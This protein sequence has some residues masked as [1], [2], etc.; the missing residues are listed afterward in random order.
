MHESANPVDQA[1]RERR[2]IRAFLP[3]DVPA[4]TITSLL[5]VAG[6][7]PS[8]SNLQP[9]QVHV[10]QG[11]ALQRLARE[12]TDAFWRGDPLQKEYEYYPTDWT[13][14]WLERRRA[15]GWGLYELAGIG[16][17]DR[18][19][20]K[21]QVAKNYAFFGAPAGL[22]FTLDR[23]VNIGSWL[24]LGMFIQSFMI[25]ATAR[26][27]ATCPQVS[28]ANYPAILARNLNIPAQQQVVCGMS[29]GYADTADPTSRL[30]TTREPVQRFT[31]FHSA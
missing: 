30:R 1:I 5:E 28:L 11:A 19:A 14:E 25:A 26:G 9:W 15:C 18:E 12:L 13:P 29:L 27:L 17:G 7:A 16:K 8:G 31:V 3:D 22:I 10:V 21:R 24:D 6:H 23:R 2:S 4:G 20:S